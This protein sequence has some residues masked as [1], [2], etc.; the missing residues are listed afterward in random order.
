MEVLRFLKK[1]NLDPNRF[2]RYLDGVFLQND[3]YY[4]TLFEVYR[5]YLEAAYQLGYC[6]EH[7]KVLWPEQLYTA[8]DTLTAELEKR[9]TEPKGKRVAVDGKSRKEK[10]EFELDGLRIIFPLTAKAIKRE[11][12]ALDHCVGGYAERHIRG[13]LTI[14]F[15]R[16]SD[17]PGVPYVTIE[18]SGNQIQQIHGY[19]NEVGTGAQNPRVVHKAFLDTWLRWLR[20]GSKRNEDGTPKLPKGK[21]ETGHGPAARTA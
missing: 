12:K 19:H 14:L 5:D 15:L 17:Q 1:Y 9:Y 8:H 20:A 16:K 18:M 13:V 4:A 2:L 21:K 7:S 10:Y 6:M 3:E 11:G